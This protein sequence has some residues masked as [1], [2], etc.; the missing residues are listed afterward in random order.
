MSILLLALGVAYAAFCVCFTVRIVNRK[1][2]WA[3]W[4]IAVVVGVPVLYV[5]SV[6]PATWIYRRHY[7]AEPQ[8]LP[9]EGALARAYVPLKWVSDGA[10][11]SVGDSIR[12][13]IGL[14]E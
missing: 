13:Y 6:G 7:K 5:L 10:P 9:S 1:E 14:W 4:T 3:K 8:S 2:R 11:K 12:W